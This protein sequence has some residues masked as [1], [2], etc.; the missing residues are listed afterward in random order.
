[1]SEH[2]L[3]SAVS[4]EAGGNAAEGPHAHRCRQES[5]DRPRRHADEP[6]ARPL[7][8]MYDATKNADE[9]M[10]QALVV[11]LKARQNNAKRAA[12]APKLLQKQGAD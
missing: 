2:N 10:T 4:P 7:T 9:D 6:G 3:M 5:A 12:H 1:M 11:P 8:Q